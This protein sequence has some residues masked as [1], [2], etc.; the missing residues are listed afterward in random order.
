MKASINFS[1]AISTGFI[2]L[3]FLSLILFWLRLICD[4]SIFVNASSYVSPEADVRPSGIIP[5]EIEND[6]IV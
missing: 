2:V 6:P 5:E 1:K 3:L 4:K